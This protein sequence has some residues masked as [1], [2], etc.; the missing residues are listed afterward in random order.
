MK[1]CEG[2]TAKMRPG[3][4]HSSS[5][6][7]PSSSTVTDNQV[8]AIPKDGTRRGA[9]V[10]G[11]L[12]GPRASLERDELKPMQALECDDV[13]AIRLYNKFPVIPFEDR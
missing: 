7:P 8:R 4:G 5:P 13:P 11:E 10:V 3:Q 2:P 6:R 12:Q 9:A 1:V